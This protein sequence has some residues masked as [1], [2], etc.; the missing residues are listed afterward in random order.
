[1]T[2]KRVLIGVS[3]LFVVALLAACGGGGGGGNS[4]PQTNAVPVVTAVGIIDVN[5]D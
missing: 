4:T 1:M 3:I 5:R 2:S